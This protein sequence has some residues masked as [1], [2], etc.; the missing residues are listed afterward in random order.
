MQALMVRQNLSLVVAGPVG[1]CRRTPL[2]GEGQL[3]VRRLR[4]VAES[5]TASA[6]NIGVY[7]HGLAVEEDLVEEIIRVQSRDPAPIRHVGRVEAGG[8]RR[9]RR[10]IEDQET[11]RKRIGLPVQHEG[12]SRELDSS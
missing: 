5:G 9:R 7:R 10:W 6:G 12:Y 3:V 1:V 2:P 8:R 11:I 4:C